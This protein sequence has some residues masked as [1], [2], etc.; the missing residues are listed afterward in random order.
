MKQV[1]I[2]DI[3]ASTKHFNQHGKKVFYAK[4]KP[5]FCFPFANVW[6]F[7]RIWPFKGWAKYEELTPEEWKKLLE[8]FDNFSVIPIVAI[9]ACWVEKDNSLTP[10]YEKFPEEAQFL[11]EAARQG[12]IALANHGL[13]HCIVGKH[14]PRFWSSNRNFHR[15]FWPSL[16]QEWHTEHIMKSQTLLEEYFE[17]PVEILVPPGNVWSYKTYQALRSTHIKKI[18]CNKYMADSEEQM[19]GVEFIDDRKGFINLHD[20]DLKKN[21][22]RVLTKILKDTL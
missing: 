12:K 19:E 2:D 11:K 21:G 4:G 16:P 9:T 10:F 17:M 8:V 5:Y 15:E 20:R 18:I 22:V 14:L 3:G 13:T 6:F 1:R 7:K